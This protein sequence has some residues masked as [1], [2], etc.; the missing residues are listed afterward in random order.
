MGESLSSRITIDPS[1]KRRGL[2]GYLSMNVNKAPG[3][4]G[5]TA[6][7]LKAD[8]Y[9][10]RNASPSINKGM[11]VRNP[12]RGLEYWLYDPIAKKRRYICM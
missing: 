8:I 4:D 10:G 9:N 5:L 1:L 3:I 11:R 12:T 7:I 6:E 2:K